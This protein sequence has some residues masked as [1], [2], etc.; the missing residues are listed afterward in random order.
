MLSVS[1]KGN[2]ARIRRCV[3]VY[4]IW[5]LSGPSCHSFPAVEVYQDVWDSVGAVYPVER[6]DDAR[7]I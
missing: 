2:H 3:S 4:R 5:N 1:K 7:R 6:L